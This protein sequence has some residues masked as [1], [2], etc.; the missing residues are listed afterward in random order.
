MLATRRSTAAAVVTASLLG[1]GRDGPIVAVV[2]ALV[3]KLQLFFYGCGCRW[4][5]LANGLFG[6]LDMANSE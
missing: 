5:I 3:G 6:F 1:Y 4:E 2:A